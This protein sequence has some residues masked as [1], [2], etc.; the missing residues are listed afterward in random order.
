ME[1]QTPLFSLE[2]LQG[3]IAKG[4][5][6]WMGRVCGHFSTQPQS[7]LGPSISACMSPVFTHLYQH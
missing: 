6:Y 5:I 4:H 7:L 1:K 3:D 2:E